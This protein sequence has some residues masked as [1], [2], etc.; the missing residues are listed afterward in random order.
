MQS[1]AAAGPAVSGLTPRQCEVLHFLD[2]G[3]SN[4]L[5]ARKLQ[6]SENTVRGHV[7]AIMASLD[8]T[9][10]AQAVYKARQAGLIA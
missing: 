4:K 8:C 5:I 3:L 1:A 10:R 2:Q 7:Q 9:S 6:L